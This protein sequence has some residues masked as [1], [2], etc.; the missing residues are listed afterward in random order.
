MHEPLAGPAICVTVGVEQLSVAVGAFQVILVQQDLPSVG[1]LTMFAGQVIT[2]GF[3]SVAQGLG[4]V[5]VTVAVF[6]VPLLVV[7]QYV[8][9]VV[10]ENPVVGVNTNLLPLS[11]TDP[12]AG[13]V[14]MV[15]LLN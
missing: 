3:T 4:T 15:M 12:F 9:V 1:V 5:T 8:K 7:K 14:L 2:G 13:C 10:P 6:D 11:T